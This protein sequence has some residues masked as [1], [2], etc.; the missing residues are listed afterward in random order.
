MTPLLIWMLLNYNSSKT[1]RDIFSHKQNSLPATA[2]FLRLPSGEITDRGGKK[3]GEMLFSFCSS[4]VLPLLSP[5]LLSTCALLSS[6]CSTIIIWPSAVIKLSLFFPSCSSLFTTFFFYPSSDFETILSIQFL[7][8]PTS[9]PFLLS[10]PPPPSFVSSWISP[11]CIP[12]YAPDP[13]ASV[14][15]WLPSPFHSCCPQDS[16]RPLL[17]GLIGGVRMQ[18]HLSSPLHSSVGYS[19]MF[20]CSDA[21][22]SVNDKEGGGREWRR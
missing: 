15:P 22:V 20:R 21:D 19:I 10:P 1:Q 5:P 4:G 16:N 6:S 7:C 3:S 2:P 9:S 13:H 8:S 17:I 11:C 14:S 18:F 12:H